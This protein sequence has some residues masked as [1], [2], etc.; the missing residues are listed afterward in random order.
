MAFQPLLPILSSKCVLFLLPS[1]A[2]LSSVTP[3][4]TA[5]LLLTTSA[6]CQLI[7]H[8]LISIKLLH[9][10]FPDTIMPSHLGPMCRVALR[11]PNKEYLLEEPVVIHSCHIAKLSQ[12]SRYK[13]AGHLYSVL[14]SADVMPNI[15]L[16]QRLEKPFLSAMLFGGLLSLNH[17][18]VHLTPLPCAHKHTHMLCFSFAASPLN[19]FF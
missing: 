7:P 17:A 18:R 10:I 5:I 6:L 3:F 16:K 4:I 1:P 12:L 11:Q 8:T 15:P 13:L 9:I 14:C 19:H 2:T